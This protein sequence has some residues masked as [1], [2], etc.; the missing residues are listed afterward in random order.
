M[1]RNE[2]GRPD[3]F[4][5]KYGPITEKGQGI[6]LWSRILYPAGVN[7]NR[8]MRG[9]KLQVDY[10]GQYDDDNLVMK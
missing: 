7:Q 8:N 6:R 10:V 2:G 9:A 1:W 5:T 4:I 3:V